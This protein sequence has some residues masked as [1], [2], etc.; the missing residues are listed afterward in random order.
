MCMLFIHISACSTIVETRTE[1]RYENDRILT[2]EVTYQV[3]CHSLTESSL[4]ISLSRDCRGLREV[5][6]NTFI[7]ETS[8]YDTTWYWVGSAVVGVGG[9]MGLVLSDGEDG[10]IV[11]TGLMTFSA[12]ISTGVLTILEFLDPVIEESLVESRTERVSDASIPCSEP[13]PSGVGTL[14]SSSVAEEYPAH[15]DG[16][17]RV[18]VDLS[19]AP[20]LFWETEEPVHLD[21][22]SLP[23]WVTFE[24]T[25][26]VRR[27]GLRRSSGSP[28]ELVVSFEEVVGNGDGM[29]ALNEVGELQ[30]E[31]TNYGDTTIDHAMLELSVLPDNQLD[32]V[33]A[34]HLASIPRGDR[35]GGEIQFRTNEDVEART[36]T[37]EVSLNAFGAEVR[38]HINV[39][40]SV[41]E[42]PIRA[43]TWVASGTTPDPTSESGVIRLETALTEG[44]RYVFVSDFSTREH[45]DQIVELGGGSLEERLTD[46]V[47]AANQD[48]I[49]LVFRVEVR[50][51]DETSTQVILTCY[52]TTSGD[53]VFQRDVTIGEPQPRFVLAAIEQL[54]RAY[55]T[56]EQSQLL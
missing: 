26:E 6:H 1:I 53:R 42:Q 55:L 36:F 34:I 15:A 56:W 25:P 46:A 17:G 37:V 16:S 22:V 9:I 40:V 43:Y 29:I 51:I 45:L 20:R 31:I 8:Q 14:F 47:V 7:V 21:L 4:V 39:Y 24:L 2:S 30:Y 5:D 48:N 28:V 27:V 3:E 11:S 18:E 41:P 52:D 35:V 32:L 49:E 33:D 23:H 50:P 12:M 13:W 44:G 54:A 19:N 38:E 10:I